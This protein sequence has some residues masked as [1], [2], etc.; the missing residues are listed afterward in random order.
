MTGP[1]VTRLELGGLRLKTD[2]AVALAK[3]LGVNQNELLLAPGEFVENPASLPALPRAPAPRQ[4]KADITIP[5]LAVTPQAGSGS[6]MPELDG[7]GN[8]PVLG[9]WTMPADYLRSY[10]SQPQDVRVLRVAGDSMEPE[11]PAGERVMVDTSHRVPSPPGVYVLWDGF[12]LVLKRLEII[13]GTTPPR[14][15]ISSIN[16]SAYPAYERAIDEVVINGR[17]V[18]KWQWR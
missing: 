10:V 4:V 1:T 7:N 2:Q 9:H 12:G 11:Y 13:M 3:A 17:V 6:D 14:L 18:G 8:H 5:E 15:R 16:A